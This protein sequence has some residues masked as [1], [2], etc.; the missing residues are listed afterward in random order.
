MS[1]LRWLCVCLA[2]LAVSGCGPNDSSGTEDADNGN[3]QTSESAA[4]Q[5]QERRIQELKTVR[6]RDPNVYKEVWVSPDD[7]AIQYVLSVPPEI[8]RGDP[9]PLIVALHHSSNTS[10][11]YLGRSVME[12][13]V[14][15]GLSEFPAII[16]APDIIGRSW[17]NERCVNTVMALATQIRDA[18]PIDPERVLITGY[19][20][21]G[22]GTWEYA[23]RFP[24][25]FTAAIAV[26]GKPP[27]DA[28]SLE[29][30]I[31]I[32]CL[33]SRTDEVYPYRATADTVSELTNRNQPV[34]LSTIEQ[35]SHYQIN[36]F[37]KALAEQQEWLRNAWK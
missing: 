5:N 28:A 19:S 8:D 6:P 13:L 30:K 20:M 27:F 16:I 21:G 36:L 4:I 3:G 1:G 35:A 22:E 17:D 34:T 29:W 23:R 32:L 9:L 14:R 24:D 37:A 25:F 26:S 10:T 7:V 18:Y 11:G 12:M 33:N 31:P 15:P 2:L